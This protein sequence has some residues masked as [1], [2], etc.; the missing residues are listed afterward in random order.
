MNGERAERHLRLAAEAGLRR[1]RT[2]PDF[3][4]APNARAV[5]TDCIARLSGVAAALTAVGALDA[6]RADEILLQF[7][8]ALA[9]RHQLHPQTAG[10]LLRP[11]RTRMVPAAAPAATAGPAPDLAP[12][13]AAPWRVYSVGRMLPFRDEFVAGELYVLSL[14][15][16]AERAQALAIAP[17][18][19]AIAGGPG[20][21]GFPE[22][23]MKITATDDRGT[24]YQV[25]FYGGGNGTHWEGRLV[26]EPAPPAG[27]RWLELTIGDAAPRARI[28]LTAPAPPANVSTRPQDRPP[29]EQLLEHMAQQILVNSA[30]WPGDAWERARGLG[31]VVA[32]LEA[33]GALSPFSPVP[34]YLATICERMDIEGH[35]LTATPRADLPAPW[36]SVL[37]WSGRR[38]RPA[39]RDGTASTGLVLPDVDGAQV[40]VTGL[41]TRG[42]QTWLH[43][44][45]GRERS[46]RLVADVGPL[47]HPRF[48]CWLRDDTGQWHVAVPGSWGSDVPGEITGSLQVLPPL[49]RDTARITLLASTLTSQVRADVPL[50]WWAAP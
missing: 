6:D 10:P 37:A 38:H 45:V 20:L 18:R 9:V 34:G 49:G 28:D 35:D 43:V 30:G 19:P 27:T 47:S 42:N 29:G 8:A 15:V 22:P 39:T 4:T 3:G 41:H 2:L 36:L 7:Q 11:A 13:P 1:S 24:E 25:N 16:T 5:F 32:G 46:D 23:F 40:A 44:V 48:C 12:G 50:H 33:A 14:L 31:D 17:M 26:I 21:A